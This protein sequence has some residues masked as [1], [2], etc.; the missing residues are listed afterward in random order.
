MEEDYEIEFGLK[1]NH[2]NLDAKYYCKACFNS[3]MCD[4]HKSNHCNQGSIEFGS[5]I[6]H[7][8]VFDV[9]A[10]LE[11]LMEATNRN[12]VELQE[13]Y[14]NCQKVVKGMY[15][16]CFGA[17]TRS[18]QMI[19][20]SLS[21]FIGKDY[22][23]VRDEFFIRGIFEGLVNE[24]YIK[25]SNENLK[26]FKKM[27][28]KILGLCDGLEDFHYESPIGVWEECKKSIEN[29]NIEAFN[30]F[31]L[32]L[33]D[34]MNRVM[35]EKID[36]NSNL[37][38][39]S[40]FL[41][42]LNDVCPNI[43]KVNARIKTVD[44]DLLG[45]VLIRLKKL[46]HLEIELIDSANPNP[47][48]LF[49]KISDI[50]GLKYL[51]LKNFDLSN[52]DAQSKEITLKNLVIL[53]LSKNGTKSNSLVPLFQIL[54]S[55]LNLSY[56]NIS[57]NI[58]TDTNLSSLHSLIESLPS[59]LYISLSQNKTSSSI[60][61][62]ISLIS[63]KS[64]ENFHLHSNQISLQDLSNLEN[65]LSKLPSLQKPKKLVFSPNM[66]SKLLRDLQNKNLLIHLQINSL[67]LGPFKY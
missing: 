34:A 35:I 39:N 1:C 43:Y 38:K 49:K 58:L 22:L 7:K 17:L 9:K 64:L 51:S 2:C 65:S 26:N 66:S 15:D 24:I 32:D 30:D 4:T 60:S 44:L 12:F 57:Q 16:E 50:K 37:L 59:I 67:I 61:S 40:I 18:L 13:I 63:H 28:N 6:S 56:L 23:Y 52:L 62:L 53:N 3:F 11:A 45:E 54:S 20:K 33:E 36:I 48:L 5:R 14:I 46:S 55:S 27:E 31:V 47:S 21:S 19:E 41:F 25:E 29:T 10:K 42:K 8:I